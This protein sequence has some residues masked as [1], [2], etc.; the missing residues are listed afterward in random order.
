[1][2]KLQADSYSGELQSIAS[3]EAETTIEFEQAES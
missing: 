1:M 2:K 3:V